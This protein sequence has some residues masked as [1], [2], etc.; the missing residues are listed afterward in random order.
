MIQI[1][2][3]A[4][5]RLLEI[6]AGESRH[7]A[8]DVAVDIRKTDQVDFAQDLNDIPWQMKD[9]EWNGVLGQYVLEHCSYRN[10]PAILKEIH[11]ILKPG[12]KLILT[13]P[14]TEAQLKWIQDNPDGWDDKDFFTSASENL[15][16]SQ[17][18]DHEG[19]S[20]RSF[21]NHTIIRNLLKG[22]GFVDIAT[23]A[24]GSR[25]TDLAVEG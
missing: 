24:Y 12:G 4:G 5:F 7:P 16:G 3:P 6:G 14:N 25:D 22:A 19:S 15:F 11:R 2:K 17:E 9:E 23:A 18:V 20:H 13:I 10:I 8:A 21:F 1:N